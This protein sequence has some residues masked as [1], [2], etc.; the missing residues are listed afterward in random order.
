MTNEKND[1]GAQSATAVESAGSIAPEAAPARHT[2]GPW[3]RTGTG[4]GMRILDA[5]GDSLFGNETYYPWCSQDESDWDLIAA[6][7]ELYEVLKSITA[8]SGFTNFTT[9][10]LE[11]AHAAIR[12]AEGRDR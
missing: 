10:N 4:D 8:E 5:G 12:K 1:L 11:K 6:A 7:P 2:P 9:E 3:T